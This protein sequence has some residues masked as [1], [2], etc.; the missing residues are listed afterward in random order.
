[1]NSFFWSYNTKKLIK[2]NIILYIFSKMK[3]E[4]IW[5]SYWFCVFSL[6][7]LLYVYFSLFVNF[8]E[9]NFWRGHLNFNCHCLGYHY[10]IG[11]S[12][13]EINYLIY[14]IIYLNISLTNEDLKDHLICREFI[15]NII[16]YN[17][18]IIILLLKFKRIV[19]LE[20]IFRLC[21]N[22]YI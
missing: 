18:Y 17:K 19:S 1:M 20:N 5:Y 16:N 6:F 13:H 8:L 4:I 11:F 12:N 22:I 10:F 3:F 7:A 21:K 15:I 14:I 2:I 9:I